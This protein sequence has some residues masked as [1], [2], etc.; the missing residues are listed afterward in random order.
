MKVPEPKKT[1]SGW[2]IQLRI[3]GQSIPVTSADRKEC[4]RE[5]ARI[6]AEMQANAQIPAV[7]DKT[8][9]N[10]LE[11]YI[12]SK[13]NV[14]SPSTIRG[15]NI[16]RKNRWKLIRNRKLKEIKPE[17]WQFIVSHE[18]T[19]CSPKTLRNAWGLLRSAAGS[20]RMPLPNDITLPSKEKKE[21]AFLSP[22]QIPIFVAA[23]K[24]SFFAIPLLLAL[25]SLRISE[26]SA[27]RWENIPP[28]PKMIRV[29]GAVVIGTDNQYHAKKTNKN[30]TSSRMVPVF[31]PE[32]AEAIERD[33]KPFGPVMTCSQN[34]LRRNVKIICQNAGLPELTVHGLRHSFASL[35]YHLQIPEKICMEIG[36][37]ADNQTMHNIYTH[38]AQEDIRHYESALQ[39]FFKSNE[40]G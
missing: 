40:A 14:L 10:I 29:N 5:A 30:L 1:K 3:N 18:A 27:L 21:K 12:S 4:I 31:I 37:W 7:I 24:D 26:I 38:I 15:Y 34:T 16:I 9:D 19:T 6:K 35:A 33:R 28:K 2:R 39:Q 8:V 23:V 17:E 25:S 20:V 13:E 22:S 11:R 36:G 32:L